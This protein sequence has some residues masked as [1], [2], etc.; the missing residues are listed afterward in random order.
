M[1]DARVFCT[2]ESASTSTNTKVVE[3]LGSGSRCQVLRGSDQCSLLR[4]KFRQKRLVHDLV[5]RL[6]VLVCCSG[7]C[8]GMCVTFRGNNINSLL[9]VLVGYMLQVEGNGRLCFFRQG[10]SDSTPVLGQ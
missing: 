5:V 4:P 2:T 6:E 10:T 9:E 8:H 1:Q 3:L 7:R